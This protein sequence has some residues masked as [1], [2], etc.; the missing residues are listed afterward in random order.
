MY[1]SL[2]EKMLNV[3]SNFRACLKVYKVDKR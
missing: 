1:L 3:S 2:P